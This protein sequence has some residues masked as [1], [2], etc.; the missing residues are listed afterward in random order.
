MS[1]SNLV[2]LQW[3]CYSQICQFSS[4]ET[5]F[6][7]HHIFL[8]TQI[9]VTKHCSHLCNYSETLIISPHCYSLSNLSYRKGSFS[10]SQSLCRCVFVNPEHPEWRMCPSLSLTPSPPGRRRLSVCPLRVLAWLLVK[11]SPSSSH[12]SLSSR[13]PTPSS[14]GSTLNWRQQSST[15][16]PAASW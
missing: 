14:G 15:T 13:C 7:W 5:N 10:S 3:R 16:F 6:M 12:S 4:N 2:Y 8:M 1:S 9:S 11:K